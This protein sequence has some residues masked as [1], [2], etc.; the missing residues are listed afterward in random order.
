MAGAARLIKWEGHHKRTLGRGERRH[1]LVQE[2][3]GSDSDPNVARLT[4]SAEVLPLAGATG[5]HGATGAIRM[6]DGWAATTGNPAGAEAAVV[7][8][9]NV[10]RRNLGRLAFLMWRNGA[11][12]GASEPCCGRL[13][14]RPTVSRSG[15]TGSEHSW[16]YVDDPRLHVSRLGSKMYAAT[17]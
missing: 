13:P 8:D 3:A 15:P 9:S 2:I 12:Q 10:D 7:R 14:S 17:A 11:V 6:L 4:G 5:E 16:H 1:C